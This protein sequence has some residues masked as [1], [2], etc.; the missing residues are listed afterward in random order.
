MEILSKF[1]KPSD[2]PLAQTKYLS[3]LRNDRISLIQ[4]RYS[5]YQEAPNLIRENQADPE[6]RV[7]FLIEYP[8]D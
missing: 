4:V 3:R 7:N 8:V 1:Y 2:L 5:K 6:L